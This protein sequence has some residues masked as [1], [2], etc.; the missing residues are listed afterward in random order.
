[1]KYILHYNGY[2]HEC[3]NY[4]V[5]KQEAMWLRLKGYKVEEVIRH[6]V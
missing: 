4:T 6:A 3:S 1:M 5:M 2:D